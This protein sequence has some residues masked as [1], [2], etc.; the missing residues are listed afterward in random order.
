MDV[1]VD[2]V[3]VVVWVVI[4]ARVVVGN[5]VVGSSAVV[6]V[7]WGGCCDGRCISCN[8]AAAGLGVGTMV[9]ESGTTGWRM[10]RWKR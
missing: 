5:R 8:S 4:V 1:D 6:V 7:I 10:S 2:V 3:V 9:D